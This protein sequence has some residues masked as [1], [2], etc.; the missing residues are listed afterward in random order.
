[1][2]TTASLRSGTRDLHPGSFAF[3]MATG[4][5][6][7]GEL[8]LGA[9]WLS[10]VLLVVAAAGYAVLCLLLV[11]RLVRF[12]AE[13]WADTARPAR[14]FGFFT[15]VAGSSVLGVR[16]FASGIVLP[17]EALAV[18]GAAAWLLLGYG[19]V[20]RIVL[21]EH[22]PEP[23]AAVNGTWLIWVVG[24]QSVSVAL[25]V[26]GAQLGLPPRVAALAAV[27]LWA[28]GALLYLLLMGVILARLLL[29]PLD[30]LQVSPP[31]WISM[32]AT[33]ITVLAGADLLTLPHG[34]PS[35]VAARSSIE[36]LTLFLW[37]FGT[38]WFP[39]LVLLTVWRYLKLARPA[40][41]Q[42]L[43]S[44]VFPL[45]MYAVATDAFGRAA[46]LPLLPGIAAA[47]IWLALAAWVS[48]AAWMAVSWFAPARPAVAAVEARSGG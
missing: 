45:G 1:M 2:R 13:L 27:S 47:E 48:V 16:L 44:M 17:A 35:L 37:A 24:T 8:T 36:G 20:A 46:G 40:Y 19:I 26:M 10:I 28:F 29:A 11:A 15:F 34:L 42:T 21:A 39:F 38:W 12:G 4:I 25:S 43:W 30:P 9:G 6:S 41:E 7:S 33:A 3:V 22:K 32:G 14:A 18:V 23:D 31:Y 5:L